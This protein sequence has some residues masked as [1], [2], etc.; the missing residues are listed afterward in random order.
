MAGRTLTIRPMEPDDVAAAAAITVAAWRATYRGLIADEAID[1]QTEHAHA[2]A[3]TRLIPPAE[4]GVLFAAQQAGTLAGFV[5]AGASRDDDA[6]AGEGEVWGIYVDPL[7]QG[8]GIGSA[9][10][11]AALGHLRDGGFTTVILWMLAGNRLADGF[12]TARGWSPDG[13]RRVEH[14]R[15]GHPLPEVRYRIELE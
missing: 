11:D 13:G 7:R 9:L 10:M 15:S 6:P 5:I 3:I 12:Y 8:L 14:T 1:S 2:A 4:P